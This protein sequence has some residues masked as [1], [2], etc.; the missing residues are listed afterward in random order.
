[1]QFYPYLHKKQRK[2]E[3][4]DRVFRVLGKYTDPTDHRPH[5]QTIY[6]LELGKYTD[7][8]FQLFFILGKYTDFYFFKLFKSR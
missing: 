8:S 6:F 2:N 4:K 5:T 1:M 7:L 3:K